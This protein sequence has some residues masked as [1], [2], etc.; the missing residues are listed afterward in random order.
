MRFLSRRSKTWAWFIVILAVQA[1]CLP[2]YGPWINFRYAGWLPNHDHIYL[3]EVDANHHDNEGEHCQSHHDEHKACDKAGD[4]VINLPPD[5][6]QQDGFLFTLPVPADG[7]HDL[8]ATLVYLW[9]RH[10]LACQGIT[11]APPTQPPRA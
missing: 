4:P 9:Q 6:L 11:I 1:V 2:I 8:P 7:W 10:Q 3:G 5:T